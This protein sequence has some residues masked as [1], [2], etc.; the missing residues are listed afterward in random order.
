MRE[1]LAKLAR[2]TCRVVGLCGEKRTRSFSAR[3]WPIENPL[4]T[5]QRCHIP[6]GFL[7]SRAVEQSGAEQNLWIPR[8]RR[9]AKPLSSIVARMW[10]QRCELA[11]AGIW[12]KGWWGCFM[13]PSKLLVR[14]GDGFGIDGMSKLIPYTAACGGPVSVLPWREWQIF[15]SGDECQQWICI[16][17]KLAWCSGEQ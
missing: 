12:C 16:W 5:K 11:Q 15:S 13:W 17:E 9:G 3:S 14:S 8:R 4:F 6:V 7:Q 1:F 10:L 2:V